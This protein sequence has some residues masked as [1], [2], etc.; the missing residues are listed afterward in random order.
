MKSLS[1]QATAFLRLVSTEN[2]LS[3]SHLRVLL[4]LR[5]MHAS[6]SVVARVT[7]LSKKRV[8]SILSDFRASGTVV[9][10]EEREDRTKIWGL[11][12]SLSLRAVPTF[13]APGVKQRRAQAGSKATKRDGTA[14][15]LNRLTKEAEVVETSEPEVDLLDF[16]GEE[17]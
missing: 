16:I 9:L 14:S 15:V 4:T 1:P 2:S 17:I 6:A 12:P 7:G 8:E 11:V 13:P 3:G 5:E 10:I